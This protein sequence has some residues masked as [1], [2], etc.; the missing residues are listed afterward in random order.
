MFRKSTAAFVVVLTLALLAPES[1]AG[2]RGPG[3][4]GGPRP[5]R[6]RGGRPI[7][8]RGGPRFL[9]YI[10]HSLSLSG[11]ELD[12]GQKAKLVDLLTAGF[13]TGLEIRLEMQA[14][15]RRLAKLRESPSSSGDD[16]VAANAELGRA[17]G[18]LE[19]LETET[20]RKI[21]AILTPEQLEQTNATRGRRPG[22]PCG[23]GRRG[24]FPPPVDPGFGEDDEEYG[25]E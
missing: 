22:Y 16:I 2:E 13:N 11:I 5:D 20:I 17:R 10:P 9:G 1:P 14:I 21:R 25:E 4:W 7:A 8:R 6:F 15:E 12:A 3:G 18:K 24:C 23:P 19:A